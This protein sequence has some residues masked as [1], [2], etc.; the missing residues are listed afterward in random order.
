MS[1]V[2]DASALLAL[3]FDETGADIVAASARGSAISAVNFSEVLVRIMA[4]DGDVGKADNAV[5]RLEIDVVPFDA[6][7]ARPVAELRTPTKH[8]G[9]SLGD[10]TC[11][12]L[13]MSRRSVVLT[14][15]KDWGKLDIGIDIRLIR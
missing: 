1:I 15:D 5:L 3:I 4:I 2:L 9:L 12:A 7:M 8:L 14:A 11:L 10:R 13:G 6:A